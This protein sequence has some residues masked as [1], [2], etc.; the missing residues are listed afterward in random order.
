MVAFIIQVFKGMLCFR[1]SIR[2]FGWAKLAKRKKIKKV[3]SMGTDVD[4]CIHSYY[5]YA[6]ILIATNNETI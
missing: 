4:G 3:G 1:H 6:F 2:S 5:S